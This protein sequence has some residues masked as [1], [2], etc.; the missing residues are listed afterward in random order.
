MGIFIESMPMEP[1]Y[2]ERFEYACPNIWFGK[3][4]LHTSAESC[5]LAF[6]Y[7]LSWWGTRFGNDHS[8]AETNFPGLRPE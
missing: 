2:V 3:Y 6:L 1:I 7:S 4:S 5:S 8:S